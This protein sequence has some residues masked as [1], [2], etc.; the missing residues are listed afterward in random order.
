MEAF[1]LSN[2]PFWVQPQALLREEKL[3]PIAATAPKQTTDRS[4]IKNQLETIAMPP[5]IL[6]NK[7]NKIM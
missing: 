1:L 6:E 7:M 3:T 4:E 5:I 2:L